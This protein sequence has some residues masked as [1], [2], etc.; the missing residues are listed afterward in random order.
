MVAERIERMRQIPDKVR[1][2]D[3]KTDEDRVGG[4]S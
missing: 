4:K 2:R 1:K 3:G